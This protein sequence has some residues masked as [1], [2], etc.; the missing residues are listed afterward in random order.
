M[1]RFAIDQTEPPE[2]SSPAEREKHYQRVA[3]IYHLQAVEYR[4]RGHARR[5]LE[6]QT[7]AREMTVKA[8][9]LHSDRVI[10]SA[11]YA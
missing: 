1:E 4:R 8:V 10:R 7:R 5:A 11:W 2:E 3:N 9:A 6:A